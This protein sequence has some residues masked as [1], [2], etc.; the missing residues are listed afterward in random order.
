MLIEL[1]RVAEDGERIK[2]GKLGGQNIKDALF[3]V[4]SALFKC[5]P[6]GVFKGA[7]HIS[8]SL[9]ASSEQARHDQSVPRL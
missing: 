9:D 6:E 4:H 3:G 8:N 5:N 1:V 2:E 7:P